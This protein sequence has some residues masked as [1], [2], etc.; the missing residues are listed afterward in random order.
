MKAP[1]YFVCPVRR[2]DAGDP[3]FNVFRR[4]Q[5]RGESVELDLTP[6]HSEELAQ[7]EADRRN[8]NDRGQ[9]RKPLPKAERLVV[10]SVRLTPAQWRRLDE[11]GG[12]AWL[13][14]RLDKAR[15]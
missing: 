12:A 5:R 14:E 1:R 11:L 2:P 8:A 13:R 15:P 6:T 7:R 9:G 4:G 3:L 10:G